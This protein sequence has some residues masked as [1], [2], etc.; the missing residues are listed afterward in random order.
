M[1]LRSQR[2]AVTGGSGFL[3]SHVVAALKARGCG[4]IAIPRKAEYDLTSEADVAR[5][6]AD[7]RPDVV[8]HLAAVVGGIGA[9]RANPGRFFY[10]NLMMGA[11]TMEYAR[12]HRIRKYVAHR[13]HLLLS[14]VHASSVPRG[15]AVER[16][17]GGDERAVRPGE[18]DAAASRPRPIGSSTGSTGSFCSR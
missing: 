13:H 6:Y 9:N 8:I 10:D 18:E 16:L 2:I 17:P 14:E 4:S 12:R 3:G 11:L 7:R 1:D 5:F 15:R